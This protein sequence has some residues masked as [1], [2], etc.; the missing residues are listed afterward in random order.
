[1]ASDPWSPPAFGLPAPPF[2]NR[3]GARVP[4]LSNRSRGRWGESLG[5]RHLRSLGFA[6]L[7]SAWR[8][9]EPELRGDLDLVAR[10]GDLLVFCEVKARRDAGRFGGAIA[11]VNA[12]K[13]RQVRILAESWLRHHSPGDVDIRFDVIAIDG[14]HLTHYEGAF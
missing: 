14:V 11:A 7:D 9:P 1:L 10:R 13:Q 4:D 12:T 5:A 3:G 6:V 2:S 8:P